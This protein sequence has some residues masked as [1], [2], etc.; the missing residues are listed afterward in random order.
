MRPLY[1]YLGVGPDFADHRDWEELAQLDPFWA[2]AT[3]PTKRFNRWET[4]PFFAR[5][6]RQIARLMEDA[7]RLGYPRGR[8]KALDFGCGVGRY[9]RAL[10]DHFEESVG[11]DVSE[12]MVAQAR[13]LNPEV[14]NCQFVVNVSRD[15]RG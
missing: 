12:E 7:E 15:L 8:T 11:V 10:A 1:A 3:S 14:A 4:E 6:H 13:Q 9:T 5:G 2:I